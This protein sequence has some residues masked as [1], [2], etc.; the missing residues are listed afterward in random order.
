MKQRIGDGKLF[1]S[2]STGETR[3][4]RYHDV[5]VSHH[6]F[7]RGIPQFS[8][9]FPAGIIETD[10]QNG[11]DSGKRQA[12]IRWLATYIRQYGHL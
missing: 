10:S 11:F 7:L 4:E 3:G 5:F 6:Q 1:G 12:T 9:K 2:W 8:V